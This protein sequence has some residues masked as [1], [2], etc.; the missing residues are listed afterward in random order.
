MA[1]M[2]VKGLRYLHAYNNMV[3]IN[4]YVLGGSLS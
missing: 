1:L 4:T 3:D 2:A